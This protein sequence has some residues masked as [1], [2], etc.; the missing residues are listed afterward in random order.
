[1][2]IAS[3]TLIAALLAASQPGVAQAT[4]VPDEEPDLRARDCVRHAQGL[5]EIAFC[6]RRAAEEWF[7][8][9]GQYQRSIS[10]L[11][12]GELR[13]SFDRAQSAWRRHVEAEFSFAQLL[14]KSKGNPLDQVGQ[15]GEKTRIY[16]ARALQLRRY[17]FQLKKPQ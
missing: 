6:E 12:D 2:R 14:Q 5:A 1:M 16:K 7:Q 3:A 8:L 9:A 11:L 17:L 15:M 13:P 4:R 10:K